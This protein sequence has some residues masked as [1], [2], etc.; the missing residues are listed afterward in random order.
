MMS[1]RRTPAQ[2]VSRDNTSSSAARLSMS[3]AAR[4]GTGSKP[5]RP[6][7][8]RGFDH[9]AIRTA[10]QR[11]VRWTLRARRQRRFQRRDL[12]DRRSHCPDREAAQKRRDLLRGR[13]LGLGG[14]WTPERDDGR[15]T[16]IAAPARYSRRREIT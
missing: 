15:V 2:R 5:P 6:H 11:A 8:D 16:G 4:C 10:G 3:R 12:L 7:A 13:N 14:K 9:F 1:M